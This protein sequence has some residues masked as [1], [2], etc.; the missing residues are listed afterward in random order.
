MPNTTPVAA[1][2]AKLSATAH[3]GMS[4]WSSCAPGIFVS[5][6]AARRPTAMPMNPPTRHKVT[7]SSRNCSRIAI[8]VAPTALRR[9]ISRVRSDTDTSMMFMMPMPPTSSEMPT[10]PP[11]IAVMPAASAL[12]C[13]MKRSIAATLKVSTPPGRTPRI[14]RITKRTSSCPSSA[15]SGL[16]KRP[17]TRMKKL[18]SCIFAATENGMK[19]SA[20]EVFMPKNRACVVST[21]PTIAK[22][23]PP[24]RIDSLIGFDG[25]LSSAM[26]SELIRQTCR[27]RS[28]SICVN[29][30]PSTTKRFCT[31]CQSGQMPATVMPSMILSPCCT[32]RPTSVIGVTA[33]TSVHSSLIASASSGRTRIFSNGYR[34][35]GALSGRSGKTKNLLAPTDSNSVRTRARRPVSAAITAV[36]LATPT[37]MPS[38]VRNARDLFAQICEKA[39]EIAWSQKSGFSTRHPPS[40]PRAPTRREG[41]ARPNPAPRAGR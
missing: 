3:N 6:N 4:A 16:V 32:S 25:R 18:R 22:R 11:A 21:T 9:P 30:R 34:L 36:V 26:A 31:T 37:M 24:I 28:S 33:L 20:L 41:G 13:S 39:S 17:S 10:M 15:T 35:R 29:G 12:N 23:R 8:G 1:L 7:A 27:S 40:R 38:A 19:I 14:R 2:K 5:P